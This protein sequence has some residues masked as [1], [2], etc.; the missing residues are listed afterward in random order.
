MRA[1][2][3]ARVADRLTV[4]Y[5]GLTPSLLVV[6]AC[7]CGL[8]PWCSMLLK[9]WSNFHTEGKTSTS[10][11]CCLL[12]TFWFLGFLYFPKCIQ[13]KCVLGH[14]RN[15]K[16]PRCHTLSH[17]SFVVLWSWWKCDHIVVSGNP[18][19]C[20]RNNPTQ[21]LRFAIQ[22][23]VYLVTQSVMWHNRCEASNVL[24]VRG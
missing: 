20:W 21:F 1:C 5:P 14:I 16:R 12:Y 8:V 23:Y 7:C 24:C 17:G 13:S 15:R 10:T 9:P 19:L 11:H 18:M 22:P 3:C 2:A 6:G 4:M